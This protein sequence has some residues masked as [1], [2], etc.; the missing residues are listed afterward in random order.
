MKKQIIRR[1]LHCGLKAT[2]DEYQSGACAHC[3]KSF[4][5]DPF[6]GKGY[7]SQVIANSTAGSEIG[8][9]GIATFF[10][11]V[12]WLSVGIGV[13]LL[14]ISLVG[15]TTAFTWLGIAVIN[16]GLI[17]VV[18]GVIAKAV[19]VNANTTQKILE[20]LDKQSPT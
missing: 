4:S 9:V 8:G 6:A 13:L 15:T 20:Y 3:E 10:I 16:A 5:E 2:E 17:T 1:C 14:I 19:V 12:G 18:L 11:V 7:T